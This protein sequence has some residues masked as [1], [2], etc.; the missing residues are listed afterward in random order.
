MGG[1][2][3]W[4][5]SLAA[6]TATWC[7][8]E[9][10][11]EP[12]L[13]WHRMYLWYFE[14]VLQQ[15]AGD[16]SLRLPFWDYATNAMLPAAYRDATY[17]NES[18][19]TVPNPLRVAARQSGINAGTSSLASGTTSAANAM[20]K[21]SYVPFNEALEDGP[22]GPVH[23]AV[24]GG[25]GVG[26]MGAV[27]AAALDPIFYAHHTNIDRLYECWLRV[28]EPARLPSNSTHL[29]TQF[30]FIDADGS[31]AVRKVSDMLRLSQLGYSYAAGGSCPPAPSGGLGLV[32]QGPGTSD[33]ASPAAAGAAA[34]TAASGRAIASTG[35]TRLEPRVTRVP[36]NVTRTGTE[37]LAGPS[38]P[39]G[40]VHLVIEGL[41]FDTT[42]GALY[43]VYVVNS[44]GAREQVGVINFFTS[45]A[46]RSAAHA[47]HTGNRARIEFD[48]TAAVQR[49][50]LGASAQP[51]LE[52]EPATGLADSAPEAA[53]ALISPQANVR[54][55]SARLVVVQ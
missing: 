55:D 39:A 35:E 42:P 21:T 53:G 43:N 14:R 3:T 37:G 18:G 5:A 6:E 38:A 12:F 10:G 47:D 2:T 9:H 19:S 34:P 49:L 4:V 30:S 16:M 33:T 44:A 52:F 27:P 36:M 23:C 8:C 41:K 11:T 1:V 17:V 22:H 13:T 46:P 40:Q 45:T 32:A 15:A 54:F 7:R 20:T 51:S 25:C 26:L 31:T 29:N 50:G 28:N 48:A 24:G